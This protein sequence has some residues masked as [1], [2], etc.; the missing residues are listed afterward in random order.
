MVRTAMM[1]L[2]LYIRLLILKT[3]ED[4]EQGTAE[5]EIPMYVY[6]FLPVVAGYKN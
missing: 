5:L 4:A 3:E 2:W 1:S 6:F